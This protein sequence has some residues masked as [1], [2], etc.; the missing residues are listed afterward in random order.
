MEREI[1]I[2]LISLIFVTPMA[3][4]SS[5]LLGKLPGFPAEPKLRG[6]PL[7]EV[8]PLWWTPAVTGVPRAHQAFKPKGG[9]PWNERSSASNRSTPILRNGALPSR[10]APELDLDH[11]LKCN[12]PRLQR[13]GAL[14]AVHQVDREYTEVKHPIEVAP[15]D[16]GRAPRATRLVQQMHF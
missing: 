15:S 10:S 3:T 5:G 6:H 4:S 8:L 7:G 13:Q 11:V 9:R 2:A 1:Q 14:P 12:V 16:P